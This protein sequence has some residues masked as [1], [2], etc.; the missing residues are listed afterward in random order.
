[1][2]EYTKTYADAHNH[3][4]GILSVEAIKLM[5]SEAKKHWD[6]KQFNIIPAELIPNAKSLSLSNTSIS[7]DYGWIDCLDILSR[8]IVLS[9]IDIKNNTDLHCSKRL[10]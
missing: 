2:K 7:N 3:I 8:I 9:A 1:M 6:T 5:L 4:N 10:S